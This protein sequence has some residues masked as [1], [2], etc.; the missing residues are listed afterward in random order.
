MI[1][2]VRIQ[3]LVA[4]LV[5]APLGC[6]FSHSAGSSSWSGGKGLGSSSKGFGS[7]SNSSGSGSSQ[8]YRDDVR[9]FT[10]AYLASRADLEGF[11][12][13]LAGVARRHGVTNWEADRATFVGI[14]AGLAQ[15]RVSPVAFETFKQ[16]FGHGDP[17][18]MAAIQQGYDAQRR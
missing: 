18:N 16:N 5:V 15:A 10:A 3:A 2:S 12:R 6:S 9:D 17:A 11:E 4:L 8:A 13:G 14:G 7:S 1:V